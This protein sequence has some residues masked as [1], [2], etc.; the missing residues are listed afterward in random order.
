[1]QIDMISG[2]ED[3]IIHLAVA[4]TDALQ[5]AVLNHISSFPEVF[6]ERTSLL[7]ERRRRRVVSPI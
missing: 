7:F 4:D 2:A 1:M 3:I 5:T 6:D